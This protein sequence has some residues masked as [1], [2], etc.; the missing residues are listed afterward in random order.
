MLLLLLLLL[1]LLRVPE[2]P[3]GSEGRVQGDLGVEPP[4]DFGVLL[5]PPQ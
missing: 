1:L 3:C 4:P 5:H 2:A